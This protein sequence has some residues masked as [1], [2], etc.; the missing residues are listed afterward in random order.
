MCMANGPRLVGPF[1]NEPANAEEVL[2]YMTLPE[3]R[4]RKAFRRDFCYDLQHRFGLGTAKDDVSPAGPSRKSE[5]LPPEVK[6][7][8]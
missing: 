7:G 1:L 3:C 2:L 4:R 5:P 6:Y 8:P